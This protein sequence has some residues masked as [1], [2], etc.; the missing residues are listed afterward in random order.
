MLNCIWAFADRLLRTC[1]TDATGVPASRTCRPIGA[2][3][4]L[5]D[6]SSAAARLLLLPAGGAA[7][8][9]AAAAVLHRGQRGFEGAGHHE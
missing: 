3:L 2:G 8:A 6:A 4:A 7:A 9:A 1:F 5:D